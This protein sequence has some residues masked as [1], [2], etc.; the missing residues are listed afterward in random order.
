VSKYDELLPFSRGQ[1]MV[2]GAFTPTV[3][4]GSNIWGQ[5]FDTTDTVHGTNKPMK[6][7]AMSLEAAVT[8]ARKFY[9]PGT[10]A[11]DFGRTI[12]GVNSAAGGACWA[13]DD[14]YTVGQVL[15]QYDVAWFIEEGPVTVNTELSSVSLAQFG[16][17]VSDNGGLI[18][19]AAP[20][21]GNVVLGRLDEAATTTNTAKVV[22]IG[23]M[24]GGEG[25]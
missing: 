17:V 15:P 8:V 21:A 16:G 20:A 2:G 12:A 19:G 25:A 22:H 5:V 18:D 24:I 14:A 13:L 7:R 23:K 1:T 6:L 3:G 10:T 11:L 9:M 4:Y